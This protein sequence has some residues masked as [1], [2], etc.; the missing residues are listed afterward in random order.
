MAKTRPVAARVPEDL[1][2][3]ARARAPELAYLPLSALLR[4]G[5]A[6]LAGR[7]LD[8]AI[9]VSLASRQPPGPKVAA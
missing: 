6:V 3:E 9:R 2:A 8:D 1:E 5:L 7:D 4:V